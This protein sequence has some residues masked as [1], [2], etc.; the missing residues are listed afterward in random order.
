[1]SIREV[2]QKQIAELESKISSQQGDVAALKS[3]LAQLQL[4]DFEEDLRESG[5]QQ[6]LNG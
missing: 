5:D 3:A 4:Q 6:L 1:M 2:I